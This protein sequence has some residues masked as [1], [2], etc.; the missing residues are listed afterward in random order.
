[1]NLLVKQ[2]A[3]KFEI[4]EGFIEEYLKVNFDKVNKKENA[5]NWLAKL[6][7]SQKFYTR[8]TLSTNQRARTVF[9]QVSRFK[10]GK[11]SRHLD[12]GC[13]YGGI[14]KVFA[15]NGAKSVGIEIGEQLIK[16]S[17]LNSEKLN[18]TVIHKSIEDVDPASLGSFDVITC[19]EVIE[20]VANP[21]WL[22][23]TASK[24]L[25]PDGIL[26]FTIPNGRSIDFVK[27]DGHFLLFGICLLTREEAKNYKFH[28]T[29]TD[30]SYDHMGEYYRYNYYSA[31]FKKNSVNSILFNN[32]NDFGKLTTIVP[33]KINQ[34][35]L[36][37]ND[38]LQKSENLPYFTRQQVISSYTRY[39]SEMYASYS[40]AMDGR[41]DV[42][43]FLRDYVTDFWTIIGVKTPSCKTEKVK[44]PW[45]VLKGLNLNLRND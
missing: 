2:L 19:T 28:L 29:G 40:G 14:L 41:L 10:Q 24:M 21:E 17:K 42:S 6:S 33:G 45:H 16:Y 37:Y 26:Y 36:A 13:G 34:L 15:S 43:D 1:M 39:M 44:K 7:E 8:Y 3:E 23:E 35:S 9:T 20:H 4:S 38:W 25:A 30:D 27:K 5:E 31:L 11:I 18:V 12:I 22:I 32:D